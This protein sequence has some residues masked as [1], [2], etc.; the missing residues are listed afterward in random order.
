MIWIFSF[1]VPNVMAGAENM[2]RYVMVAAAID[3][4][5]AEGEGFTKGY[6]R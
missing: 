1:R 4:V 5:M 6:W 3:V 2:R